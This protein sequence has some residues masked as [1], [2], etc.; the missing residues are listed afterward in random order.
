MTNIINHQIRL[1][2]RPVGL[3]KSSDWEF[4]EAQ[5]P[6]LQDGQVL[7]KIHYI[8]VDPAMRA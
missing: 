1:A 7:V 3:P 2:G 8:S 5:L 4:T 6:D